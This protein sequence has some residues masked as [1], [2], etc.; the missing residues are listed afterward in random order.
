M[1]IIRAAH[2]NEVKKLQTLNQEVFISDQKYDPD[3]KM[4][5]ALSK[6]G[7]RYFTNLLNNPKAC[8]LMAEVKKRAIGYIAARPRKFSYRLSHY[9]EIDNM[10]V[11]PAFRSQGIGSLLID[12]CLQ[13]ARKQ[14]FE[15]IYVVTYFK[16]RQAIKFY[17]KNSFAEIDLSFERKI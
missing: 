17:K 2:K 10:G 8:C 5:W 3:L 13:W 15:K 1:I 14:G 7:K 9:L 4:D 11:V 12:G 16:N 6:E